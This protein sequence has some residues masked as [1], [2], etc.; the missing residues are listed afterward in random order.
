MFLTNCKPPTKT[1]QQGAEA[2][3]WGTG[4]IIGSMLSDSSGYGWRQ[5]EKYVLSKEAVAAQEASL[6]RNNRMWAQ[7]HEDVRRIEKEQQDRWNK[8]SRSQVEQD[9]LKKMGF[10]FLLMP[11]P[12]YD[13]LIQGF[14]ILSKAVKRYNESHPNQKP[15]L[16][17][18]TGESKR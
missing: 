18:L 4:F 1:E 9:V 15:V 5:G 10:N 6:D 3:G 11:F 7:L 17:W 12:P 14:P 13:G 8:M 16:P 2:K